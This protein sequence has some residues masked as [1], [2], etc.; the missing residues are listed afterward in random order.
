[1]K[2]LRQI[3]VLA[4]T[5][6]LMIGAAE[7]VV[8]NELFYDG[9][10]ADTNMFTELKG[11]PGTDLAG[12]SL[13]GVNG[14]DGVVY[15]TINLTGVIP[16]DGYYV[17]GQ[18]GTVVNVDQIAATADWQNG[19]DQVQLRQG[20]TVLDGVCYGV[21]GLLVC[22]GSP[23]VDVGPG[24]SLARCPDGSDTDDNSV[25]FLADDTPTPGVEND[26]C[27]TIPVVINEVLYD[28]TGADTGMFTELKGNPG[29][30]LNGYVLVGVNGNDGLDYATID[31]TGFTIPGDGYFV[32]AQ[33]GTVAS[34]DLIDPLA[35]FQ[36][37]PDKVELREAGLPVDGVCYGTA[38]LLTCEGTAAIDTPAGTSLARCPDGSDTDDN[39]VDFV[40]DTSPTPGAANDA[41]CGGTT[42]T[43]YTL[44]QLAENDA[45]GF[46][47]HFGELVR[48]TDV[49][50]IVASGVF[51]PP[52][53]GLEISIHQPSTG[54]CVTLFD[55]NYPESTAPISEG[56][57]ITEIIG[58][59]DFFNG[60][61][62]ITSLSTVTLGAVGAPPTPTDV[63]TAMLAS[64]GEAYDN[65]LIKICGAR[66]TSGTWPAA[67]SANLTIDDGSGP[68]IL[69]VDG[70]TDVDGTPQPTEPF[71]VTGITTQFDTTSPYTGDYQIIPRRRADVQDGVACPTPVSESTWGQLKSR[72]R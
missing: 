5:G 33:D 29:Q 66:I 53:S 3:A 24:N 41:D 16:A 10:G 34:A 71:T 72:Y 30:S 32:I 64:G 11:T 70:D 65:C 67:G 26:I 13:V 6:V 12:Y 62:E 17:V 35:D 43:D 58:S 9:P 55:F 59:V 54:C 56:Q 15:T 37:G 19:P 44:C 39:S 27:P 68:V 2:A 49:V 21:S 20:T 45:N 31:L 8:I 42:P 52:G 63:T 51:R 69:R 61:T 46:P 14:A 28:G 22:E 18:A 57:A 48:I 25:D 60:K 47:I 40:T 36:N 23:A 38:A 1:M 50:A 4:G 7:A